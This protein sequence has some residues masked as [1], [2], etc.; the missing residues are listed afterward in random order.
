[1]L[2]FDSNLGLRKAFSFN[3]TIEFMNKSNFNTL[4]N[5]SS[6]ESTYTYT[7]ARVLVKENYLV[8]YSYNIVEVYHLSELIYEISEDSY[9]VGAYIHY[10]ATTQYLLIIKQNS[11]FNIRQLRTGIIM[12][13]QILDNT[14][15]YNYQLS[16]DSKYITFFG[17]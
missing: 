5:D 11:S 4:P 3:P 12:N 1:M 15:I 7:D 9:I 14:H 6:Y 17:Y 16:P 8:K 13:S 10:V 2:V